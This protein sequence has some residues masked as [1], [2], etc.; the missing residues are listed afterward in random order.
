MKQTTLRLSARILLGF[1]VVLVP[2]ILVVGS[3][4]IL[5]ILSTRDAARLQSLVDS[6]RLSAEL[7]EAAAQFDTIVSEYITN[8]VARRIEGYEQERQE[9][10]TALY[11]RQAMFLDELMD[12]GARIA[13]E[14]K[15]T[16]VERMQRSLE[17]LDAVLPQLFSTV[18][19]RDELVTDI[20]QP[21][22]EEIV[23][24]LTTI[25]V[26]AEEDRDIRAAFVAGLGL[27]DALSAQLWV[28]HYLLD[29]DEN[30]VVLA[31]AALS[32]L[33]KELLLLDRE[34][35]NRRRR[36]ILAQLNEMVADY[37]ET[38]AR[39]F[40]AL[41]RV[42]QID[43]DVL[44]PNLVSI[45][46]DSNELA[47]LIS[48]ELFTVTNQ[49]ETRNRRQMYIV[50]ILGSTVVVLG[51][52]AALFLTRSVMRQIGA[53]PADLQH[54][55]QQIA[56]G[57]LRIDG[58]NGADAATE[59]S[60]ESNAPATPEATDVDTL[61]ATETS[62]AESMRLMAKNQRENVLA[63]KQVST[64][65]QDAITS[66]A[67]TTEQTAANGRQ[68]AQNT[69]AV[70]TDVD[71]INERV[72]IVQGELSE[73][74]TAVEILDEQVQTQS[75]AT[76]QSTAS[77]EEIVASLQ[78]VAGIV[79]TR[80]RDME[81]LVEQAQEGENEA[82]ETRS[83]VE[84]V[85]S[86]TDEITEITNVISGITSQTNLL[87]MNAAIEA[88]HAG[89]LGKGFAV[90]ADEIRTLAEDSAQNSNRIRDVI[91]KITERIESAAV[92]VRHSAEAFQQVTSTARQTFDAY[93][94]LE[95]TTGEMSVGGNE[96]LRTMAELRESSNKVRD[97]EANMKR[98]I[99][100]VAENVQGIGE[101]V[102]HTA[103]RM[104]EID[105]GNTEVS[106]AINEIQELSRSL[107]EEIG[108]LTTSV[109]KFQV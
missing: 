56:A 88:A 7:A 76:E 8:E 66:L 51:L 82:A 37:I 46:T 65:A 62:L 69:G 5:Q 40:T 14:D 24:D 103:E 68:M 35:Q 29:E 87:A 23:A 3:N 53:D 28:N 33:Q 57:D 73:I 70:R 45:T 91:T 13:I 108:A 11:E 95:A 18:A 80:K 42:S 63:I 20:L 90:V 71:A 102:Q 43:E 84:Q 32:E 79:T 31:Q 44:L 9:E 93:N 78:S 52:L 96:V 60:A 41:D 101:Q 48:L 72:G 16:L 55:A 97:S 4:V 17:Q 47:R 54:L 104:A 10:L 49:A 98:S 6:E 105:T 89:E 100:V 67:G 59:P 22:G 27:R 74:G 2:F 61:K 25:L 109:A 64:T 58:G 75:T 21:L 50:L 38:M 107:N 19:L 34:L 15:I 77:V 30:D 36:A 12:Q 1:A 81:V 26:S 39:A 83:V 94:E 92:L 86:F 85:V 99:L 106:T